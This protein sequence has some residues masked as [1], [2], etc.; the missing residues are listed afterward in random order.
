MCFK[1]TFALIFCIFNW[2]LPTSNFWSPTNEICQKHENFEK[3]IR[4]FKPKN[5][6]LK[7]LYKYFRK[8]YK[9]DENSSDHRNTNFCPIV[10]LVASKFQ[11]FT[12]VYVFE[13]K[14]SVCLFST[15]IQVFTHTLYFVNYVIYIYIKKS[16]GNR[17]TKFFFSKMKNFG[18]SW[19]FE[20]I[21]V[22]IEPKEYIIW[23]FEVTSLIVDS[24]EIPL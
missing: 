22:K 4:D 7:I 19:N 1:W 24:F 23:L 14:K 12:K 8:N 16:L 18:K 6:G 17:Q 15:Y 10:T 21:S 13:K 3:N 20:G 11:V 2:I 9:N 5:F